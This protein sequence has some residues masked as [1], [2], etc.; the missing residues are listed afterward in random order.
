MSNQLG[1]GTVRIRSDTAGF[2]ASAK[3]GILGPLTGIAKVAGG[4]FA[5]SKAIDFIHGTIDAAS[6]LN[7][8]ITKSQQVFKGADAAVEKFASTAATK[9]GI[10]RQQ[11]LESTATFGN[12]F[13]SMGQGPK[14][15]ANLSTH[16]VKLAGDLASFNN[17]SPE[18]AL[19][20]LRSGV[21]GEVEPLRKFGVNLSQTAIQAQALASGIVKPTKN[22][23]AIKIAT[24]TAALAQSKYT[25]TLAK[26]GKGSD[27][28]ARAGLAL[29]KAQNALNKATAGS[30]PPLTASQKATAAYQLIMQQTKLA[31]GDFGRT[32]GGLA[33]QQRILAAQTTD[34]KAKIGTALLPTMIAI[35][36]AFNE[37]L[38]WAMKLGSDPTFQLWV[39]RIT[40]FV[41]SLVAGIVE[42]VNIG[43][44]F[45]QS[46]E[47]RAFLTW[48]SQTA[49][50]AVVAKVNS[51][52]AP[53]DRIVTAVS[54]DVAKIVQIIK[55]FISQVQQNWG[56]LTKIFGPII[57]AGLENAETTV[58]TILAVIQGA[59]KFFNDLLHGRWLAA[60]HDLTGIVSDVLSGIR[61][62]VGSIL[63]GIVT[64]AGNIAVLIGAQI[65]KGIKSAAAK[66]VGLAGDLL[67]KIRA[68]ISQVASSAYTLALSIGS[69]IIDGIKDGV[70]NALPDALGAIANAGKKLASKANPL[71]YLSFVQIGSTLTQQIAGSVATLGT[72]L[73]ASL[74]AQITTAVTSAKQ[75]LT[76]L[77]GSLASDINA[78]IDAGTAAAIAGIPAKLSVALSG[79]TAGAN[80]SD[81]AAKIAADQAARQ[82]RNLEQALAAA[83][84][85]AG[86]GP[87]DTGGTQA[88]LDQAQKDAQED[89]DDFL[90]QAQIDLDTKAYQ[91]K[92]QAAQDAAD[93]AKKSVNDQLSN[94]TAMYNQGLIDQ[95]TYL[96][97]ITGLIGQYATGDG[98]AAWSSAGDLLGFAFAQSMQAHIDD[99]KAQINAIATA[100][101]AGIGGSGV[102]GDI[103]QPS[104]VL[105][106]QAIDTLK[107]KTSD[108]AAVRKAQAALK[109]AQ[110]KF[111][112]AHDAASSVGIAAGNKQAI[113]Q[114]ALTKKQ[115]E[116]AQKQLDAATSAEK[117][118]TA[119][120][121]ALI[122]ILNKIGVNPDAQIAA[123]SR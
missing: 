31:Q 119:T 112:D 78:I 72:K 89:L 24:E 43:K 110:G 45:A 41:K 116:A 29:E 56:T 71:N 90:L 21:V 48:L 111:A 98:T 77:T 81:A 18:E 62:I 118:D 54:E 64:T 100:G 86:V 96:A 97:D 117:R 68:A 101:P 106:Q 55:G 44:R 122:A 70:T 114:A 93:L 10:S 36:H 12:L 69:K 92:V 87:G 82:K 40:V 113:D 13:R 80:L 65:A 75:N 85:A 58:R 19:E 53:F 17:V 38:T 67:A 121:N 63:R 14:A 2:A 84:T 9:L 83:K 74:T 105:V 15:A 6:D 103:T 57:Q 46:P 50:P 30:V 94:W 73:A 115:L 16:L 79:V 107:D 22:V 60:W 4:L 109:A 34:L 76:G 39:Q 61:S 66:L 95:T 49:I 3:Q 99:I 26:H 102:G 33:N 32:S 104:D 7:E 37:T 11:A 8:S 23:A 88:Q 5:A 42:L 27:E 59:F 120:Y 1:E 91:S 25:T 51:L 108:A 20:A 28:A 47:L 123:G 52:K 35:T